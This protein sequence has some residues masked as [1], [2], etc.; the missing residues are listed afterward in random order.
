MTNCSLVSVDSHDF[1]LLQK[2]RKEKKKSLSFLDP[3][4]ASNNFQE[5]CPKSQ[6]ERE[7]NTNIA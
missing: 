6:S 3:N 1:R 2:R 5:P 7:A 4:N